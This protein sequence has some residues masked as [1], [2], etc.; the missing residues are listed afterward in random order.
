MI[1][2]TIN[3]FLKTV[4]ATSKGMTSITCP[5]CGSQMGLQQS[6]SYQNILTP[7]ARD[8]INSS[9]SIYSRFL[10]DRDRQ[11]EQLNIFGI[12]PLQSN[13]DY[14]YKREDEDRPNLKTGG[15]FEGTEGKQELYEFV[16]KYLDYFDSIEN[17]KD[18]PRIEESEKKHIRPLKKLLL[19]G[20][21]PRRL[22]GPLVD[23]IFDQPDV[24]K[25][26]KKHATSEAIDQL[27]DEV[28]PSYQKYL[29]ALRGLISSEDSPS[30]KSDLEGLKRVQFIL[31]ILLGHK[32]SDNNIK[33]LE[34]LNMESQVPFL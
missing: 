16:K 34:G 17:M 10:E 20:A 33:T 9:L 26:M 19:T 5:A 7:K 1:H 30:Q 2:N 22:S 25:W 6:G 23:L 28:C 24:A 27:L 4:D 21:E 11:L 31:A 13:T 18:F 15:V 29:V 8:V 12:N 32:S 3:D 14:P